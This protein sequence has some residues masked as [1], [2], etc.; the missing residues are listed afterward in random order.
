MENII[1]KPKKKQLSGKHCNKHDRDTQYKRSHEKWV[2]QLKLYLA[3]RNR[4]IYHSGLTGNKKD[5]FTHITRRTLRINVGLI[6]RRQSSPIFNVNI[7]AHTLLACSFY[8][9]A[10]RMTAA[11][12]GSSSRKKAEFGECI[13][14]QG[15]VEIKV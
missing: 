13:R 6:Y 11:P 5:C 15:R 10:F 1:N 2:E 8:L 9:F 4:I 7:L 14:R 12:P 3:T